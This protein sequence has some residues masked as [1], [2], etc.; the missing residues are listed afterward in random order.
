MVHGGTESL[1]GGTGWYTVVLGQY[2]SLS[3]SIWRRKINGDNDRPTDRANIVQSAFLRVGKKKVKICNLGTIK[4][5][6]E[7][8]T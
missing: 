5:V 8:K 1:E 7:E 6:S 2:G 4:L 3:H